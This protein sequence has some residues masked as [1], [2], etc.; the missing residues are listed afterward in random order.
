MAL[1]ATWISGRIEPL[2]R[3]SSLGIHTALCL[4]GVK[5]QVSGRENLNDSR[6]TVLLANHVSH[7]DPPILY[8][9]LGIDL[10]AI[11][12]KEV[13]SIPFFGQVLR[14]AGFVPVDRNNTPQARNA[15][16]ATAASLGR[17]NCFLVFPEGT[18]SETGAL[19]PFKKGAFVAA[20][21]AGSRI[22][23]VVIHGTQPLL[24]RGAW[25]VRAGR[26]SVRILDPVDARGY[27]YAERDLL[28][29]EVRGRMA[30][31]LSELS[32]R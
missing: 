23:P 10:K 28:V 11:A 22:V 7:L 29:E 26:V 24:P 21:E 1:V 5:T 13:F 16:S 14:R 4:A 2:Y 25:G 6:N 17:G 3:L 31:A 30:K 27:S 18:R 9:V 12:K 32:G 15:V 19:L 8:D 20:I